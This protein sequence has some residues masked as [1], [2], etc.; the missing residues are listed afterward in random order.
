[1]RARLAIVTQ[2][3]TRARALSP[4]IAEIRASGV[5]SYKGIAAELHKRGV[6]TARG[7]RR[8]A[9]Q[10]RDIVLRAQ[11]GTNGFNETCRFASGADGKHRFP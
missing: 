6:P 9:T 5:Q 10:V 7:G 2:A 3:D 4:V 1:V 8:A 11:S